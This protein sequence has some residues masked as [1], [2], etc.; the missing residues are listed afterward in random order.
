MKKRV[1]ATILTVC[2]LF[3]VMACVASAETSI[4]VGEIV[5]SKR[6]CPGDFIDFDFIPRPKIEGGVYAE[7]WEIQTEGGEWL[8]Y[9]GAPIDESAGTFGLRYF[10]ADAQ[11]NYAYSNTCMVTAKHNPFGEYQY[12]GTDHW[13]IC[14][15]CGGQ[16]DKEGHTHLSGSATAE[17][18]VCS[19]CGH[20]R[21]SQWTGLLA[22][23]E[24][25]MDLIS[26]L[27]S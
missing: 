21:T 2:L 20:V 7:G 11:G 9:T 1:L 12:S 18:K 27:F 24:W 5:S 23:W 6:I 26:S 17:D 10:A 8:P 13:R 15:D 4:V 25:I 14:V 3:S 19:V 22:F 16:A